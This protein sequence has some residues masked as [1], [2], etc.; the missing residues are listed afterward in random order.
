M[1]RH[2]FIHDKLDIKILVLFILKDLPYP[3]DSDRL[4]ELTL[5]CDEAID[6]FDYVQ[7]LSELV[8]SDHIAESEDGYRITE[9]GVSHVSAIESSLPYSVRTAA[10]EG[11]API[12][13][14]MHRD[15]MIQTSVEKGED[16]SFHIQLSLS[17]GIGDILSLR[18]LVPSDEAAREMEQNFRVHAESFYPQILKLLLPK[19]S[20]PDRLV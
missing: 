20:S 10:L 9:K 14:T 19:E 6:Y 18:L 15:S 13:A 1:E 16:G 8:T 2:G 5:S 3:L 17:D 11:V 12:L 4:T 7:C